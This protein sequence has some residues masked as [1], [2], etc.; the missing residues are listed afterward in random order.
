MRVLLLRGGPLELRR[1]GRQHRLV[2]RLESL[3]QFFL[4]RPVT[5]ADQ[6]H[7]RD[8]SDSG[9]AAELDHDLGFANVGLLDIKTRGLERAEELLNDPTLAVEV[10]DPPR[11]FWASYRVCREKPPMD[12]LTV[13][14]R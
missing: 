6:L 3:D 5:G 9:C 14:E 13:M 8:R 4:G 2:V 10:D 1:Q 11:L 12:R 7:D